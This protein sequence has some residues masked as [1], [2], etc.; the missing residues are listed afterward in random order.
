MYHTQ[1]VSER[2]DLSAIPILMFHAWYF[3]YRG[4]LKSFFSWINDYLPA[5]FKS[6]PRK[7]YIV[8]LSYRRAHES[9]TTSWTLRYLSFINPIDFFK[10]NSVIMMFIRFF[11]APRT[12]HKLCQSL[13]SFF[14][15][16]PGDVDILHYHQ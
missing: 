9:Y 8:R 12:T 14:I 3:R 13:Q 5:I 1:R 15:D 4:L 16:F 11:H 6:L 2:F 10:F 7:C